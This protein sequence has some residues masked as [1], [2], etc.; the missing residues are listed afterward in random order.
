MRA[1]LAL[2]LLFPILAN[3]EPKLSA[4]QEL[5]SYD[6]LCSRLRNSDGS[7]VEPKPAVKKLIETMADP[8]HDFSKLYGVDPRAV[9]GA[10]LAENSMN[11]QMDDEIQN[12]I[13]KHN[14]WGSKAALNAGM[15]IG[16]GQINIEPATAADQYI[17]SLGLRPA[18]SSEEITK[19]LL[20]PAGAAEYAAAIIRQAQDAYKAEGIDISKRP[21]VLVTLYNFG[22]DSMS[23]RARAKETAKLKQEPRPNF[24]GMFVTENIETVQDAIGWSPEKGRYKK[25]NTELYAPGSVNMVTEDFTLQTAPPSCSTNG[26]GDQG[27]WRARQSWEPFQTFTPRRTKFIELVDRSVDCQMRE[28]LQVKTSSG[29]LG[30]M[31]KSSL[32]SVSS[33]LPKWRLATSACG[34]SDK[35]NC[36]Q[37]ALGLY[38][39]PQLDGRDDKGKYFLTVKK[40]DPNDPV[41]PVIRP[42]AFSAHNLD[43]SCGK[44]PDMKKE[45]EAYIKQS[46][47]KSQAISRADLYSFKAKLLQKQAELKELLGV[48]DEYEERQVYDDS[49]GDDN[50][51]NDAVPAN[52][53]PMGQPNPYAQSNGPAPYGS[54]FGIGGMMPGYNKAKTKTVKIKKPSNNNYVRM[55]ENLDQ[56]FDK[57]LGEEKMECAAYGDEEGFKKFLETD[58]T[59]IRNLNDF[60]KAMGLN[61]DLN[62]IQ[63]QDKAAEE[64]REKEQQKM[65]A[66]LTEK[67]ESLA[68]AVRETCAYAK[69]ALPGL[70]QRI[71]SATDDLAQIE[72]DNEFGYVFPAFQRVCEQAWLLE[73]FKANGN[74][75]PDGNSEFNCTYR[76]ST[77]IENFSLDF[78]AKMNLG[79]DD[80]SEMLKNQFEVAAAVKSRAATQPQKGRNIAG[81]GSS[82]RIQ[83][84]VDE[85]KKNLASC[86]YNPLA[87]A[88]AVEELAKSPCVD[89]ILVKDMS[90]GK[91]LGGGAKARVVLDNSLNPDQIAFTMKNDCR[92]DI[93]H[94]QKIAEPFNRDNRE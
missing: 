69:D 70:Y 72:T 74:K 73:E 89:S 19:L 40:N 57:C 14:I 5:C 45:L 87:T 66:E 80:Y 92:M 62:R 78:L 81:Q 30:W 51:E 2:L 11:V 48:K 29:E 34:T 10:I 42:V 44:Y 35:E 23:Y 85:L 82:N 79:S 49:A 47:K 41:A 63:R 18:R 84:F 54:S 17:A 83:R 36:L 43:D 32:A 12:W 56:R 50:E 65:L 46:E 94:R 13:V 55:L 9:A 39:Q 31:P 25:E 64:E 21:D 1:K 67:R 76:K 22:Q 8:V 37:K 91:N 90:L 16:P 4:Y 33:P 77:G 38:G 7:K 52:A 15:T 3:A 60:K 86:N 53:P 28:W 61:F 71:M 20:T 75:L 27:Q 24:F 6:A 93:S 88:K 68:R 59:K 58:L 26:A